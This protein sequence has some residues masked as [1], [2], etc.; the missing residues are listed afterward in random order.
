VTTRFRV[1]LRVAEIFVISGH[2]TESIRVS[3][4]I[5]DFEELGL[6]PLEVVP[7]FL[8]GPRGIL[9]A[10]LLDHFLKELVASCGALLSV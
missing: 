1:G 7:R 2:R 8:K 6:V 4:Y 9:F 5:R 3:D 10:S